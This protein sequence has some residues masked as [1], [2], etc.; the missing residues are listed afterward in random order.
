MGYSMG[1]ELTRF[2]HL[3]GFQLVKGFFMNAGPS[4]FLLWVSLS[5]L[6][7]LLTN[8]D[9]NHLYITKLFVLRILT[10]S[11]SSLLRVITFVT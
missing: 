9:N 10:H 11:Y 7:P 3:N 2:C 4:F 6:Y 5:L 8:I 1:L